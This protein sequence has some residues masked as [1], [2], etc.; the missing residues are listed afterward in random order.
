MPPKIIL[1]VLFVI[2]IIV[3]ACGSKEIEHLRAENDSLRKELET[4][5]TMVAIMR[6]VK[7]LIDSIDSS[8][9]LLRTDLSEG[10]TYD[11]FTNRLKDINSYVKQTEDKIK[12]IEK[13][14]KTSKR[15]ASA[16]LMMMDALKSE[17]AIR[18]DEVEQLEA[19]VEQYKSENKGLVL[20][21]KVQEDEMADM[22]SKIETKQRELTLLEAKVNELVDNFKVSEAEAYYARGKAVEEAARRTRLAARKKKE[23]YREAL[24]LYKRAL[25]LGKQ[26]AKAN[27]AALE[28]KIK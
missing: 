27:I 13:E 28:K 22:Q 7:S 14:M 2:M 10:T 23:T 1:P 4:R 11:H 3:A 25:S 9:K 8:R 5:H 20:K 18:V 6:D 21:V 16:Y 15:Q 19:S 17:L 26:E 12:T 24:E